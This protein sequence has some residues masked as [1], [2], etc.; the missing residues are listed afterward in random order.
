[1]LSEKIS[2]RQLNGV[3]ASQ[4]DRRAMATVQHLY[5]WT[6]KDAKQVSLLWWVVQPHK[7]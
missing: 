6:G 3:D 7:E 4:S 2:R 5:H 1:M